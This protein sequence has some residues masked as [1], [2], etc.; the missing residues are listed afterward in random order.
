MDNTTRSILL[1]DDDTSL[2][3]LMRE[4]FLE[5]G[6]QIDAAHQ[7][8]R[9][10]ARALEHP[11]DLV[12]LDVMLPGID[13]FE[14]LKQ[15][16]WRSSVPVIL[17]TARTD[18]QDRIAGLNAGA[19][20]Y[21]SKPFGPHELLARVRAVLRRTDNTNP[22]IQPA[23][24]FGEL[25]LDAQTRELH[26]RNELI[27]LT[28]IEFAILDV[29]M[30]SPGRI[31]S[32]SELSAILYQR[33]TT[34][35]ERTRRTRA[36]PFAAC[37]AWATR[38]WGRRKTREIGIRPADCVGAGHAARVVRGVCFYLA[39]CSICAVRKRHGRSKE[40]FGSV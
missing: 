25:T 5:N 23:I 16:R 9:G 36:S 21:L 37:A 35:F 2:C 20:D 33:D 4:F 13:G 24:R 28:S 6:F 10:L 32:R 11:Y 29:L 39:Q 38:W 30:R 22:Q 18:Q 40:R 14:V 17:L 34:P 15:L 26:Y 12:I 8:D 7:G 1:I 31:V 3:S 19:D 27:E